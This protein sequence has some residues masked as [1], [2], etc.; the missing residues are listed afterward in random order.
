MYIATRHRLFPPQG[1]I[2]AKKPW[3]R[4]KRKAGA[5]EQWF[6]LSTDLCSWT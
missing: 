6:Q 3:K 4:A 1:K 2:K 5:K